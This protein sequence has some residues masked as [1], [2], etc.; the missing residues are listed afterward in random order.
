MTRLCVAAFNVRGI[1]HRHHGNVTSSRGD[2]RWLQGG[3][4]NFRFRDQQE[5]HP[6]KIKLFLVLP[7]GEK[8][9][10]AGFTRLRLF[11]G[12]CDRWSSNG[13]CTSVS[14]LLF[15]LVSDNGIFGT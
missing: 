4:R 8:E 2:A 15:F 3:R 5:F 13:F 14:T 1:V 11:D 9:R 7:S 10:F 12:D 6:A